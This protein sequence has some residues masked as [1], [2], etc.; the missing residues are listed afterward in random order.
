MVLLAEWSQHLGRGIL[1]Y[2]LSHT[3]LLPGPTHPVAS[4]I[5]KNSY[6]GILTTPVSSC[7][8]E[9]S[10]FK[11]GVNPAV[12]PDSIVYFCVLL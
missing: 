12:F 10:A 11:A 7:F 4:F 3:T 6:P 8:Q 1:L 9:A 2:F 5:V